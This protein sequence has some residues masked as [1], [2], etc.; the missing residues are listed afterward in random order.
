MPLLHLP[1][2]PNCVVCG[3]ANR[4]GLH[5]QLHVDPATGEIS[6]TFTP[7]IEHTGFEGI[8]HGGV[9]ATVLDEALVWSAIWSSK[10]ACVAGELN[11]RFRRPGLVGVTITC[12]AR[13]TASRSR[14]IEATAEL[15][16]PHGQL[17]AEGSGKYIPLDEAKTQAFFASIIPDPQ[18]DHARRVLA[19]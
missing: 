18:T 4:A 2:T 6:T 10:H 14:L 5:L 13:V 15:L 8:L 7:A 1:H 16:D 19:G 17:I 11:V 9:L 12:R 3:P